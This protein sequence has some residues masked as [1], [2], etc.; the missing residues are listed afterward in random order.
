MAGLSARWLAPSWRVEGGVRKDEAHAWSMMDASGALSLG[1]LQARMAASWDARRP[2]LMEVNGFGGASPA[3]GG[4]PLQRN[5]LIRLG[6]GVQS[7]VWLLD[8]DMAH[9]RER[10]RLVHRLTDVR[11]VLESFLL[12]G[13]QSHSQATLTL[14]WRDD[15]RRGLYGSATGSLLDSPLDAMPTEFASA[16][17]GW[18]ALLFRKDLDLD[19]YVR[20]RWWGA[21]DGLRLHTPTGLLVLPAEGAAPADAGWLVDLV[22]EGGVRGATLFVDWENMFSGTSLQVG[23]LNVPDYP[24]PRQRVRFGVYWPMAN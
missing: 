11:P 15:G 13:W 12:D 24:L 9:R 23:N 5:A 17:L 8:L 4:I 1:R 16:R 3:V 14:G 18:R 2:S 22:A 19:A 10:D 20:T 21:M 6:L 7:G